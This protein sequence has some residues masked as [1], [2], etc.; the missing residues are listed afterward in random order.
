[1]FQLRQEGRKEKKMTVER[2]VK[3]MIN[4]TRTFFFQKNQLF[5]LGA[6]RFTLGNNDLFRRIVHI[7]NPEK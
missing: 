2:K 7:I 3:Q 6:N 5:K 1:M 4:N